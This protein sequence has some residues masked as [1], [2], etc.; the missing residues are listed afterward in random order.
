MFF[1]C[2]LSIFSNYVQFFNSCLY[3]IFFRLS[4]QVKFC[5]HSNCF[6]N[7]PQI[8]PREFFKWLWYLC[9]LLF[10]HEFILNIKNYFVYRMSLMMLIHYIN[11]FCVLYIGSIY[12]FK[13]V[14]SNRTDTSHLPILSL[15]CSSLHMNHLTFG[16]NAIYFPSHLLSLDYRVEQWNCLLKENNTTALF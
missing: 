7:I 11:Y 14:W 13:H 2:W 12:S 9:K 5:N 8:L 6:C 16:W 15:I 1:S 3:L 10:P 4:T